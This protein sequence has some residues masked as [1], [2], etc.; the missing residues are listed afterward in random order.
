MPSHRTGMYLYPMAYSR[1]ADSRG[2]AMRTRWTR[3]GRRY[4]IWSAVLP[5]GSY[6]LKLFILP[7][8]VRSSPHSRWQLTKC[9]VSNRRFS[10]LTFGTT[11]QFCRD[12]QRVL[13][14]S[15]RLWKWSRRHF[16]ANRKAPSWHEQD[17]HSMG[18]RTLSRSI[19]TTCGYTPAKRSCILSTASDKSTDRIYYQ[20]RSVHID[21]Q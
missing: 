14:R 3:Q 13:T 9:N 1:F 7:D 15:K 17:T 6:V 19:A 20:Y 16:S 8:H 12:L 11:S 5:T 21:L 2:V 4:Y 18:A 10:P